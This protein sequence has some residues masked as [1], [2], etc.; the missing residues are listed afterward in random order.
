MTIS[1]GQTAARFL[2]AATLLVVPAC[3][4][5]VS[6]ESFRVPEVTVL[7]RP[8]GAVYAAGDTGPGGGTVFAVF[9]TPFACGPTLASTCTYLEAAPDAW[10]GGGD[11][12]GNWSDGTGVMVGTSIALGHGHRNTLA[13]LAQDRSAGSAVTMAQRYDGGGLSDWFLP[14]KQELNELCEYARNQA[15]GDI[16]VLCNNTGTLR[17]GFADTMYWSSSEYSDAVTWRQKF[18]HGNPGVSGDATSHRVR[19]VR[20]G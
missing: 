15:T 1:A 12:A 19:P 20:A 14:S 8:A 11:P 18:S 17:A 13:A 5:N 9:A 4:S 7:L 3:S 16:G 10:S 6:V 2:A